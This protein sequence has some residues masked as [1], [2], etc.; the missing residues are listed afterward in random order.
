MILGS[1]LEILSLGLVR[2]G[3]FDYIEHCK[4]A[5]AGTFGFPAIFLGRVRS[6]EFNVAKLATIFWNA[7]FAL[8]FPPDGHYAAT[9]AAS[10][11]ARARLLAA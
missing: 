4:F 2:R 5:P 8:R 6:R 1:G 7:V 3:L 10:A 9:F 11:V